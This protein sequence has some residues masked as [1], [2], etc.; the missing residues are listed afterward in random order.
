MQGQR[1][2]HESGEGA[3]VCCQREWVHIR[4]KALVGRETWN[5]GHGIEGTSRVRIRGSV[6]LVGVCGPE[7]VN[8]HVVRGSGH[9]LGDAAAACCQ[10]EMYVGCWAHRQRQWARLGWSGCE[11]G[12]AQVIRGSGG[13]LSVGDAY[14]VLAVLSEAVGATWADTR[15]LVL[16]EGEVGW[17]RDHSWMRRQVMIGWKQ[18]ANRHMCNWESR[19][20]GAGLHMDHT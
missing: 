15:D 17:C 20:R 1:S 7:S 9:E 8:M 18:D 4:Q 19:V 14:R 10:W 16:R 12:A 5:H 11:S 2:R 3:Y 6:S 13:K